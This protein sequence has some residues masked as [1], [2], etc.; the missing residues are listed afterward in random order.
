MKP[1]FPKGPICFLIVCISCS[2]ES[3]IQNSTLVGLW[4]QVGKPA[5]TLEFLND[6]TFRVDVAGQR[7]MGGRFQLVD[8]RQLVLD[9]DASSP[10]PGPFT[11]RAFMVGKELRLTPTEGTVERYKRVEK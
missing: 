5:A 10:K 11:N 6:G 7:L 4:Q 2:R 3:P 1:I 8:E 9:F